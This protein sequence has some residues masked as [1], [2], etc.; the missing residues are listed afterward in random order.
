MKDGKEVYSSAYKTTHVMSTRVTCNDKNVIYVV[1]C[2]KC[3]IQGVGE[4]GAPRARLMS[5]FK[6]ARD[7]V[8]PAG[9]E[10]AIH[11]HFLSEDHCLND[12][13]FQLVDKIP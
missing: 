11:R 4:C 1:T 8:M 9:L 2:T 10:C 12:L 6:A 13:Q 5:Y 3:D 7:H